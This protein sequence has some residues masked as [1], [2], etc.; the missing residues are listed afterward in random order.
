MTPRFVMVLTISTLP[1]TKVAIT[2]I[3]LVCYSCNSYYVPYWLPSF[4]LRVRKM[5]LCRISTCVLLHRSSM[6]FNRTRILLQPYSFTL[7]PKYFHHH[8]FALTAR[9]RSRRCWAGDRGSLP[10]LILGFL[11][12][13][14]VVVV[15]RAVVL[16]PP[17]MVTVVVAAVAAGGREGIVVV[18][19]RPMS[20]S[21][22]SSGLANVG[23]RASSANSR[24]VIPCRIIQRGGTHADKKRSR[25]ELAVPAFWLRN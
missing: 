1:M 13:W 8:C 12:L 20:R 19:N 2:T 18:E 5:E 6:P 3:V 15:I 7:S 4:T 16:L 11:L 9:P 14:L 10:Q 24:L 21:V 22:T 25:T 17:V 23:S